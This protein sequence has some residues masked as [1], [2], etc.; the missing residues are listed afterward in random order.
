MPAG[1]YAEPVGAVEAAG[2]GEAEADG[3]C[4]NA[5]AQPPARNSRRLEG[6]S[7]AR[8]AAHRQ[9]ELHDGAGVRG[10]RAPVVAR[11]ARDDRVVP[12]GHVVLALLRRA[13]GHRRLHLDVRRAVHRREPPAPRRPGGVAGDSLRGRR[14]DPLPRRGA[15]VAV[16]HLARRALGGNAAARSDLPEVSRVRRAADA[17]DGRGQRLLLRP[18]ADV[19][20]ARHRGVR[21]GGEHRAGAAADLRP[22]GLPGDGDRRGGL[23]DGGRVV[24]RGA[25]RARAD[26]AQEVSRPSST[27]PRAGSRSANCS[28][29]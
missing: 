26:A 11:P 27:P 14:R 25:L 28:A 24:G 19:D 21:H 10:H 3:S 18:R 15:A 23:G 12:G 4:S 16:A 13:A 6:T 7:Q 8:A 29:G 2:A 5:A 22:L 1:P 20:G 17:R 9:P